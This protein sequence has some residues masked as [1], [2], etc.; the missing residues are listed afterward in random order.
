MPRPVLVDACGALA[1]LGFGAVLAAVILGESRG[2]L[3]APG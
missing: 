3:A 1:G 2:S